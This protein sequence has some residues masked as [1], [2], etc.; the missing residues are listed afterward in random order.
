VRSPVRPAILWMR[1]VSRASARGIAGRIVVSRRAS[2]DVPAPGGP[3]RSRVWS[4]RLHHLQLYRSC[5]R[6]RWSWPLIRSQRRTIGEGQTQDSSSS[7]AL[8]SW[9]SAVSKPSVNQP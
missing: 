1:V 7:S 4:K 8:A 5:Y 9:R 2:L 6:C 3:S